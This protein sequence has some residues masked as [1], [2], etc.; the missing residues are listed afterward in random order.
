MQMR[1]LGRSNLEVSALGLGDM[2]MS[3][4]HG[5]QLQLNRSASGRLI[6]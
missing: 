2:G 3:W 5:G 4:F 6:C 1:W